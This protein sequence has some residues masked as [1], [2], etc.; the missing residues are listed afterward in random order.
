MARFLCYATENKYGGLHGIEDIFVTEAKDIEEAQ[1]DCFEASIELMSS[2]GDIEEELREEA[3]FCLGDEEAEDQDKL[4]EAFYECQCENACAQVWEVDEEKAKNLS[5]YELD[6]IA[7]NE[8]YETF[9]EEYCI[10]ED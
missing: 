7:C 4:D 9:I 6:T 1:N 3:K 2:Y 10:Q 5:T 8:G